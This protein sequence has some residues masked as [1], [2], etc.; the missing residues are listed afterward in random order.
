M[1]PINRTFER[2]LGLQE[3]E[4]F[5]TQFSRFM[6]TSGTAFVKVENEDLKK[7]IKL[8]RPDVDL[9]SRKSLGGSY[10]DKA[11]TE[12]QADIKLSSILL[13]IFA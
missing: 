7:A 3:K 13:H 6:Y 12:I 1:T 10:L 4:E 9:P 2:S 8:L 11:F 5:K